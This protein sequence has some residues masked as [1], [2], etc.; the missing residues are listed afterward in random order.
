MGTVET[1]DPL[2]LEL[3]SLPPDPADIPPV[4]FDLGVALLKGLAWED[5]IEPL[6]CLGVR[7]LVPVVADRSQ[8]RWS[9]EQFLKKSLRFETKIREAS[10]LSGRTDRMEISPPV[11]LAAL[12]GQG[13]SLVLLLDP[14]PEAKDLSSVLETLRPGREILALIG[15][16]GGWSPGE[17]ALLDSLREAGRGIRA[18]LGPLVFPGRLAPIVAGALISHALHRFSRERTA[19]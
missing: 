11:P 7:T 10:Q 6:V 9:R 19:L 12:L 8:L 13:E 3:R 2:V 18:G 17:R 16:E 1:R 15:P 5:L 4:P 14:D